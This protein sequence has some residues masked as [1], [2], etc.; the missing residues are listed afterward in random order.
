MADDKKSSDK[1]KFIGVAA[2]LAISVAV[3]IHRL[4]ASRQ[5]AVH[6]DKPRPV[7]PAA[8]RPAPAPAQAAVKSAL[9]SPAP[10]VV[11]EPLDA[12][13]RGSCTNELG[14]LCY[15]IFSRT[16]QRRCLRPFE[17]SLM[18]PC[19]HA[20]NLSEDLSSEPD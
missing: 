6:E 5:V 8:P 2:F 7:N 1:L 16:Q 13:W 11:S 20:L 18:K 17:D 19:R 15:G 9:L 3:F 10:V 12:D 14:I 4:P